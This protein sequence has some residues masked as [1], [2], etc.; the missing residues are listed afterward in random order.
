MAGV[1]LYLVVAGLMGAAGVALSAAAAHAPKL[2]GA[3][4]AALMLVLHAAALLGLSA[5]IAQGALGEMG[6]VALWVVTG[7]AI[8]FA[9]AVVMPMLV[10][11]KLFPFAAPIGGILMIIGW[12]MIAMAALAGR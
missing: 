3:G 6:R 5:L 10:G 7:G 8:L 1:S 9:V 2:A 12:L 11:M 4:S